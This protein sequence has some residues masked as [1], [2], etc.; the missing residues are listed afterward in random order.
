MKHHDPS[1]APR[2]ALTIRQQAQTALTTRHGGD[3]LSYLVNTDTCGGHLDRMILQM[4]KREGVTEERKRID[5][6]GWALG[7]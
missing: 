4:A 2:S 7:I 6:M 3:A 5:Q 1:V